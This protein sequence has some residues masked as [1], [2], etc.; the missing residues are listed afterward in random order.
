[1][2]DRIREVADQMIDSDDEDDVQAS[3]PDPLVGQGTALDDVFHTDCCNGLPVQPQDGTRLHRKRL[4]VNRIIGYASTAIG[5]SSPLSSSRT[6]FERLEVV[7]HVDAVI[8]SSGNRESA[9]SR[10]PRAASES[11][12]GTSSWCDISAET[13]SRRY[14]LAIDSSSRGHYR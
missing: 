14:C 5:G 7:D 8:S 13:G 4:T 12:I 3:Q 2:T 10:A 6:F 11:S 1:M 9:Y